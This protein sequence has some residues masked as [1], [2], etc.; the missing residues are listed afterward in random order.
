MKI[1][2]ISGETSG[3]QHAAAVIKELKRQD[4]KTIVRGMGGDESIKAGMQL[5]KHQKDLAFMGFLEVVKNLRTISINLK[6]IKKDVLS[7][8]PDMVLLIDYPGFNLRIAKFCKQNGIKVNYY[9]APKVWAWKESRVK[10]LQAYVSQLFSILPFEEEYFQKHGVPAKY[11]GNPSRSRVDQYVHQSEESNDNI[12]ALI[13]GSRKQEIRTSLPIMLN[14]RSEFPSYTFVVSQAPGFDDLFYK[15]FDTDIKLEPDMYSLLRKSKV[16]LVTSGT[17]TLETAL[18]NIPQIVCYK[19]SS[20]TYWIAKS[21]VKLKYISLVNLILDKAVVKEL[22]QEEFNHREL[23]KEIDELLN[24]EQRRTQL[25]KDYKDLRDS[26][27]MLEPAEEVVSHIL[28]EE[29]L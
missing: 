27:G 12:I 25:Y 5:Y 20:I 7:F 24:N 17:A 16:A 10:K 15:T 3:D 8:N 6:L 29:K 23:T 21:L 1:Y 4:P 9:I 26:L 22:I 13:P 18:F 14:L 28:G 19:T 11:V 2:V